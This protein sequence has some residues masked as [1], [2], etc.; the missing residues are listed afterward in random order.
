MLTRA[1]GMTLVY[2]AKSMES[3]PNPETFD[4]ENK[5]NMD[6]PRKAVSYWIDNEMTYP[7]FSPDPQ[8]L[9]SL[10]SG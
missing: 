4:W 8:E 5:G 2:V 9:S 6:S 3:L 7:V 10:P 1:K